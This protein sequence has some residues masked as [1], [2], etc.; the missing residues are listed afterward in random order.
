MKRIDKTG[1]L[2]PYRGG[3]YLFIISYTSG[4]IEYATGRL[5]RQIRQYTDKDIESITIDLE[6]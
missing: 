3:L 2:R 6:L 4:R 1:G 5:K